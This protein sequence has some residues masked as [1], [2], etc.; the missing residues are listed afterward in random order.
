MLKKYDYDYVVIG[1]GAA[2]NTAAKIAA[3]MGVKTAIVESTTWGGKGFN[4]YDLPSR[5]NLK[6]THLY[7]EALKAKIGLAGASLRLNYHSLLEWQEKVVEKAGKNQVELEKL[8]VATLEGRAK[9]VKSHQLLVGEK[10]VS[11]RRFLL[12]TGAQLNTS[13]ISG[14]SETNYLTPVEAWSLPRLP[15][16]V[17]IV[18]GGATGCELAQYFAELGVKTAIVELAGRLL[19]REDEEVGQVLENYFSKQLKI[20]VLTEVRATAISEDALGK[21]VTIMH[22]G[23]ES[24]VRM[25]AVV[26]ATGATPS[27]DLE[28]EKVGVKIEKRGLKVNNMLQTTAKYIF[29]AGDVLGEESSAERAVYE[30]RLATYNALKRQRA[31][32]HYDGFIRVTNT[33]PQVASVGATEDDCIKRDIK[34]KKSL[35][36][37]SRVPAAAINGFEVGFVKMLATK[38]GKLLGATIVAPEAELM[39]QEI[40]VA[41]RH[42]LS[43]VDLASTPCVKL[44]WSE[45]I[46]RAAKK[47]A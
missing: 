21:R 7:N 1:S 22:D 20:E 9:F 36:A 24:V 14:V 43:I 15:K 11:G 47:L 33:F 16:S 32:A 5:A 40:A 29:A 42:N 38:Q 30:G 23:R 19:P 18:G 3:K 44:A 12:A 25:D 6:L 45:L 31:T 8:G 4:G 41:I 17:L 10:T 28:L 39:I 26:L 35:T 13:G 37:L 2:G 34:F 46:R 27:L